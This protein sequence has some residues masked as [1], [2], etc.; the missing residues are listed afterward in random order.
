MLKKL[1]QINR[2]D[3]VEER[4]GKQ[5]VILLKDSIIKI[6]ALKDFNLKKREIVL[7][8]LTAAFNMAVELEKEEIKVSKFIVI[9]NLSLV[10][11]LAP[12]SGH[13]TKKIAFSL[14]SISSIPRL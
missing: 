1:K 2:E 9:F 6:K 10:K 12:A 7:Q 8:E 3:N 4:L 14:P 11:K 5:L 13:S